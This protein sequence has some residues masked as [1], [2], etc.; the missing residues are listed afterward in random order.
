MNYYFTERLTVDCYN[1]K[2]KEPLQAPLRHKKTSSELSSQSKRI[3]ILK[4][5]SQTSDFQRFSHMLYSLKGQEASRCLHGSQQGKA[6]S[7]LF[8]SEQNSALPLLG[9]GSRVGGKQNQNG[10]PRLQF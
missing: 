3:T 4:D 8:I 6:N 1:S 7:G 9:Y 5:H 2:A 10:E